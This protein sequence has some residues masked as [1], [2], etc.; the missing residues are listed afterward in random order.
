MQSRDQIQRIL[1]DNIDVR[2]VVTR[3]EDSYQEIMA[4]HNYPVVIEQIL[5][6]MLAAVTIL[7]TNLKF[8]GKLI[9]QAKGEGSV[10]ALMAEC[11]HSNECRAIAQFDE[12][13][14]SNLSFQEMLLKGH[15][16]ITIEP[17][18]GQRYQG[19]VPLE[20]ETLA[21]CLA[22]YFQRSEQLDTHF[23][24]ACDGSQARGLMLQVMP[25][26]QSGEEDWQRL[27]LLASTLKPEELLSLDNETLLFR[28]F[29]EEQCRLFEAENVSFKCQCSRQR[30]EDVLK[31]LD[32]DELH[33]IIA[34]RGNIEIDCQ[35]CN[36][37]YSFDEQDVVK[38]CA[39]KKQTKSEKLH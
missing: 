16:V 9:L 36:S 35:F 5:G 13:I 29:H 27:S 3:L 38:I 4:L 39:E 2:G 10:S 8:N 6:Q 7:S 22:D 25:A 21:Q 32:S 30:S 15:L 18:V 26:M 14:A 34:E 12:D 28:L 1:F 31:L 11:N 17:E 23:M 33:E 19:F 37:K 20:N 24:L